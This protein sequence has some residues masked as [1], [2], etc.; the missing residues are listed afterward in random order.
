[1]SP[2]NFVTRLAQVSSRDGERYTIEQGET[3]FVATKPTTM[4][5][6]EVVAGDTTVQEYT[7]YTFRFTPNVE[8]EAGAYVRIQ[9]PKADGKEQ[10][11]IF[12]NNLNSMSTFGG[13]FAAKAFDV[14]F[15]VDRTSLNIETKL[16]TS[17]AAP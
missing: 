14:P 3:Q 7:E 16:G 2:R 15:V 9:F 13:M 5:D 4:S 10:D 1:M 11:Y 17:F 8:T 6:V 12:D